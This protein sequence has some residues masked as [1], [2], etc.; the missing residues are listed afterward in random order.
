MAKIQRKD[1]LETVIVINKQQT[2]GNNSGYSENREEELALLE[3][4]LYVAGRPLDL[5][6]LGS[7]AGV[8]SEKEVLRLA[9]RLVDKYSS[10]DTCL[11]VVELRGHHFV[12]QLKPEYARRVRRVS[13]KTV[14]T[15]GPLKTLSYV[16]YHQP[17]LQTQVAE[18]RG[19]HAYSHLKQ[20]EE[21]DLISRED[22]GRTK[23]VRT[24]EHFTDYFGLSRHL[25]AMKRQL[26]K[27]FE[28]L[29]EDSLQEIEVA[30]NR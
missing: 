2:G 16:A 30:S 4:G 3:A 6:T 9:R 10:W 24:T 28:K 15:E 14:L 20:L 18:A 25:G 1:Q 26:K 8:Q 23:I 13:F 17:V 12:F 11:E 7:V 19:S 21:L 5:T 27:I 29:T 22:K